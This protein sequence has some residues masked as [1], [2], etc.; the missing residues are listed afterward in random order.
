MNIIDRNRATGRTARM[1][2][3]A[4][5]LAKQGKTVYLVADSSMQVKYLEARLPIDIRQSTTYDGSYGV[6]MSIGEGRIKIIS[7]NLGH[8]D[9]DELT[10]MGADL[11][12]VAFVDHFAIESRFRKLLEM[13]HRFDLEVADE[14]ET[15]KAPIGR[16][17]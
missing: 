11:Q 12:A 1:L 15:P 10:V 8:I 16:A 6:T 5:K 7:A 13:Y 17:R 3:E 14:A 4:V 9:W 2:L